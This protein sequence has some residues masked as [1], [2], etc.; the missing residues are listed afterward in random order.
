MGSPLNDLIDHSVIH[1]VGVG[2]II[3]VKST[4]VGI[5]IELVFTLHA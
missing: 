2:T 5:I 3:V 4:A 1:S